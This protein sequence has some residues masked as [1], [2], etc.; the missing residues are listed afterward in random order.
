MCAHQYQCAWTSSLNLHNSLRNRFTAPLQVE[1]LMAARATV[2]P[3]SSLLGSGGTLYLHSHNDHVH[4]LYVGGWSATA[5]GISVTPGDSFSADSL[6]TLHP[7][8][9]SW[10][11]AIPT[12]GRFHL[13]IIAAHV[14][15]MHPQFHSHPF[16]D[17]A[18]IMFDSLCPE[19]QISRGLIRRLQCFAPARSI[20]RMRRNSRRRGSTSESPSRSVESHKQR[21]FPRLLQRATSLP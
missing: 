3:C 11:I 6:R 7:S 21:G 4:I 14:C 12:S 8:T 5:G 10:R 17:I 2:T 13:S 20:A 19:L 9:F 18:M 16:S 15:P 1:I